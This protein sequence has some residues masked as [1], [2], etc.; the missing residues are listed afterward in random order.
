MLV[1]NSVV[2]V[3]LSGVDVGELSGVDVGMDV[4]VI[5]VVVSCLF[6]CLSC[7]CLGECSR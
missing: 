4:V 6:L 7:L 3:E 2:L 5:G 1:L